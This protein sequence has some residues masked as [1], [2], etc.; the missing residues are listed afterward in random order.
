MAMTPVPM[1]TVPFFK[2]ELFK[3]QEAIQISA[4]QISGS[5]SNMFVRGVRR[6][7]AAPVRELVFQQMEKIRNIERK[8]ERID[9]RLRHYLNTF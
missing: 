9:S 3:F 8:G 5:Y 1:H 2:Q 6:N 4:I 7:A